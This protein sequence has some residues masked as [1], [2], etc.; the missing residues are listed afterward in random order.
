M[1]GRTPMRSAAEEPL[2]EGVGFELPVPRAMEARLKVK[3]AGFGC[4]PPSILRLPS[5]AISS[6]AKRNLGTEPLSGVEP[7]VRIHL[8]P[9]ES[10][11]LA[12]FRPPTSR[13]PFGYWSYERD[14]WFESGSLQ[15]H[16]RG[17]APHR[18]EVAFYLALSSR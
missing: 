16:S 6:G 4:M 11:C 2:G 15:R 8:P 7:D 5:V 17:S 12:G 1:A 14:R 13:D 9:A 18:I 3:I 10:P